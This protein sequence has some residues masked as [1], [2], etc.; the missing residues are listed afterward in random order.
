MKCIVAYIQS[1]LLSFALFHAIEERKKAS[2]KLVP[3]VENSPIY[4]KSL[5]PDIFIAEVRDYG[6]LSLE[7]W[8]E[9]IEEIKKT[10][11]DCK[12][13]LIADRDRFP[14]AAE[15]IKEAFRERKIDL[16]FY[17]I[18]WP[19]YVADVVTAM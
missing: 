12:I 13:I 15:Q 18:A 9:R 16:F 1:Q 10:D 14:K 6:E 2:F 4:C 5:K 19:D 7:R 17:M 8:Y 3:Q 11:K